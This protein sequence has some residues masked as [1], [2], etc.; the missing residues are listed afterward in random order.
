[1]TGGILKEKRDTQKTQEECH[2]KMEAE[3]RA[4]S[5]RKNWV[6]SKPP[7]AGGEAWNRPSLRTSRR[8]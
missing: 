2:L 5:T 7:D 3:T 4:M 8:N 6:T 1:M